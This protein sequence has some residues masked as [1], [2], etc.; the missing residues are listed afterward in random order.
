VLADTIDSV[1]DGV[2]EPL[3]PA[4]DVVDKTLGRVDE[5]LISSL[6][7]RWREE[8]WSSAL[9]MISSSHPA[10]RE[11]LRQKIE[12]ATQRKAALIAGGMRFFQTL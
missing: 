4:W 11:Q 1:Q 9:G 6:I 8:V 2:L 12:S 7:T 3:E 10:K 5:W